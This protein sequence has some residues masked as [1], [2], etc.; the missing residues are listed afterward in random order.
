MRKRCQNLYS[1]DLKRESFKHAVV[2]TEVVGYGLTL[3]QELDGLN[4]EEGC[5]NRS[6]RN[7]QEKGGCEH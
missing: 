7:G 6:D 1:S 3:L 2:D 5:L 4:N